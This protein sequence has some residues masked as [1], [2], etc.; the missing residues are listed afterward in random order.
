MKTDPKSF[1]LSRLQAD[2]DLQK[3]A[4]MQE[5]FLFGKKDFSVFWRSRLGVYF[6]GEM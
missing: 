3:H 6:G 1:Y 2:C 5:I 4:H